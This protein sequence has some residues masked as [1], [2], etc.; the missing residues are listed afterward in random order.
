MNR[1]IRDALVATLLFGPLAYT[2]ALSGAPGVIV[3]LLAVFFGCVF[4]GLLMLHLFYNRKWR[5]D[6]GPQW[7]TSHRRAGG[8][9][10]SYPGTW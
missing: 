2:D 6:P 10:L 3:K 9:R 7:R 5:I 8:R 1:P 4:V